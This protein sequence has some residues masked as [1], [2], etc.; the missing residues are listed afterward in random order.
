[1][2][3]LIYLAIPYYHV[4]PSVRLGRFELANRVAAQL[5]N[6]GKFVFSPISH[7]HPIALV[8]DLPLDWTYWQEYCNIM[9]R[10]CTKLLVIKA[11]GWDVSRGV[12]EEIK[13]ATELGLSIEYVEI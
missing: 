7:G 5:M 2:K 9:L 13:I 12:T 1:V 10:C 4:T 6:E 8:G 3:D 11:K